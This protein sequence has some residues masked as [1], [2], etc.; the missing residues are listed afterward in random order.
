[1]CVCVTLRVESLVQTQ[2][3]AGQCKGIVT[4]LY[5]LIACALIVSTGSTAGIVCTKHLLCVLELRHA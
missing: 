2:R 5:L 4:I 3:A 1:M